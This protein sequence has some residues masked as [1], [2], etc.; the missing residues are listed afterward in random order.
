MQAH[1]IRWAAAARI[2]RLRLLDAAATK[3]FTI[4]RTEVVRA[5]VAGLAQHLE[6]A[7]ELTASR[8]MVILV[9]N[10]EPLGGAATP[11]AVIRA[12]QCPST[13]CLPFV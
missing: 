11:T 12:L 4:A 7:L 1:L 3:H 13:D 6:I 8:T 5:P 2:L 10:L 9:V